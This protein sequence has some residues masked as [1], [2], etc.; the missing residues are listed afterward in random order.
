MESFFVR[1]EIGGFSL[2][3]SKSSGYYLSVFE[4]IEMFYNCVKFLVWIYYV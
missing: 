2:N 4:S 1:L 3:V